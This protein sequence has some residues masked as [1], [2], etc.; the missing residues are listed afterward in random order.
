MG[1]SNFE[2]SANP[3]SGRAL[4]RRARRE[5]RGEGKGKAIFWTL[6]I[7]LAV[8]LAIK[9]V[10]PYVNDY[11]LHDK[12]VTEARYATVNR[13]TD[14]DLRNI[15]FQEIQDLEIPARREDIKIE[16]TPHRVRISV[17]YTVAV[18]LWFYRTELHFNPST[19]NRSLF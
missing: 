4:S 15:V 16:N 5:E 1:A 7:L 19:E 11:Q 18:D 17:D 2:I 8:F 10:P 6:V 3:A 12:L 13:R 14:E 9:V